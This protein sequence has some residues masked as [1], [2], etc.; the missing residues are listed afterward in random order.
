MKLPATRASAAMV[1]DPIVDHRP[2][3]GVRMEDV[4]PLGHEE[5]DIED[6]RRQEQR[7]LGEDWTDHAALERVSIEWNLLRRS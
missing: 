3:P 5:Q 7:K 2:R 4:R 1:S 6:E